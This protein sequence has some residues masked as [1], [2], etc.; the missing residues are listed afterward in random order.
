MTERGIT[1]RT[2]MTNGAQVETGFKR[3]GAAGDAAFDKIDRGQKS[4]EKSAKVFE[5]AIAREERSFRALKASVDPAYAAQIR[6][7]RVQTQVNNAVRMGVVSQ[8][9]AAQVM[10]QFTARTRAMGA[11]LESVD[12]AAARGGQGVRNALLQVN[13]IGQQAAAGTSLLSAVAIQ[14]PDI[15][16]GFGGVIPLIAGAAVGLGAAFIPKLFE[17]EEKADDLKGALEGAYSSAET[18]LDAAKQAQ[19][20]Y[21]AAIR[22]SGQAQSQVTPQ[23]LE[24]LAAEARAREALAKLEVAQLERQR[25]RF[26]QS[27]QE[28]RAELD[29][30]VAEA[31]AAI[32]SDPNDAFVNSQAEQARLE[33]ARRVLAENQNLVLSMR[34]QQAELDLI[35]ALL[36]QN[37]G[38]AAAI[39]DELIKAGD[40]GARFKSIIS[41]TDLSRIGSQAAFLA[42]QM[43]ISA[44]QAAAYNRALNA[45]AGGAGL[46]VRDAPGG[47]GFGLGS[48]MDNPLGRTEARLGYGDLSL[49]RLRGTRPLAKPPASG[50]G[51]GG[52]RGASD[53]QKALNQQMQEAQRIYDSTRTAQ[54]N[55]NAE[56]AKANDLL[57]K[58]LITQETYQRHVDGLKDSLDKAAQSHKQMMGI[59]T[60]VKNAVVNSLM[61]QKNAADQL[62]EALKKAAIEYA[63]FGTGGFARKGSSFK[64]L[65]GNVFGKIFSFDGGGYTGDGA[66]SGGIDG[67][68]GF[69]AI[70]HP[71]ET[72]IDHTKPGGGAGGAATVDVRVGVDDSGALYA[73]VEKVSTQKAAQATAA[74][75]QAMRRSFGGTMQTVQQRGV[76]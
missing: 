31:T 39:V 72:M 11:A 50:G 43:G 38:E 61:G 41:T 53:A 70:N 45:N 1:Y 55:Y 65:L 57:A 13:Q 40:E 62:R 10:A 16:G 73:L 30:L 44:D 54:E 22:L 20:R 58:G 67:K 52:A 42:Q 34:E 15:L 51:G 64:G 6:F 24:S 47:L 36:D 18:A 69:L 74:G 25:F 48:V 23:I 29:R 37:F 63:L 21:T 46:P 49:T 9:E 12:V 60:P 66:R 7:D 17:A 19:D 14:L 35:N 75:M 33:A 4:A 26:Q 28:G 32:V 3:I 2:E 27:I 8:K 68:G 71:R 56:L 76:S 59:A 5:Q